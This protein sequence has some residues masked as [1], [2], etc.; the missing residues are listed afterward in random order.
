[1]NNPSAGKAFPV[2]KSFVVGE[3]DLWRA[4]QALS[5]GESDSVLTFVARLARENAWSQAHAQQAIEEYKRFVYLIAKSGQELTPSDAVD[6][7][8]HLHLTYTRCYWEGMCQQVLG[9]ALHHQPT[10]GGDSQLAH[11]KQTYA[12]TLAL[13]RQ[14]FGQQ[15]PA[16]IWPAVEQRFR[17]GK[18]FQRI[19]RRD[20][21]LIRKPRRLTAVPVLALPVLL[22]VTACVPDGESGGG[23]FWLKVAIGV[24]GIYII[25][26]FINDKLG[27]G[28]HGGGSGGGCGSAGCS[29]C[30]G[31]GGD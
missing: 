29:G 3:D 19:N 5:I 20:N 15:P 22:L 11:F 16:E 18:A 13:Y 4:L 25:A 30:A 17:N 31:C 23:W 8:W 14:V 10:R 26:K 1:M 2:D 7:V 28:K 6:Q 9:F 21:W 12:N 24:W 27:G